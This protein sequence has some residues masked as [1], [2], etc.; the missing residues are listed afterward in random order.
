MEADF[1]HLNHATSERKYRGL[2]APNCRKK[3]PFGKIE[4]T[5]GKSPMWL[6]QHAERKTRESSG[7]V[8]PSASFAGHSGAR[9]SANSDVHLHI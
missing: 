8:T 4:L 9:N 6:A 2:F 1:Y 5:N 3:L 7:V